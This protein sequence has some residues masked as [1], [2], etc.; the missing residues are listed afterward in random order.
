MV[1]L[2]T[3]YRSNAT[4][5]RDASN[6]NL[7]PSEGRFQVLHNNKMPKVS[8]L[9]KHTFH[10][11]VNSPN[12]SQDKDVKALTFHSHYKLCF[13]PS[14]PIL[15]LSPFCPSQYIYCGFHPNSRSLL[16]SSFTGMVSF[17]SRK[18]TAVI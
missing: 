1:Q 14:I 11:S 6:S 4:L 16:A 8:F 15:S 10:S 5:S 3:K 13:K 7:L 2:V 12:P 9:N 17:P 18:T